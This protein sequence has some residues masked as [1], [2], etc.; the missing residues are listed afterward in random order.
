MGTGATTITRSMSISAPDQLV[1]IQDQASLLDV[2]VLN[3]AF[4]TTWLGQPYPRSMTKDFALLP[5]RTDEQ[6]TLAT[7]ANLTSWT[8]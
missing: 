2:G 5:F 3:D 6:P 7:D 8:W 4:A 1:P